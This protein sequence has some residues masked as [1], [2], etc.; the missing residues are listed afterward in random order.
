MEDN[1]IFKENRYK[2]NIYKC[3]NDNNIKLKGLLFLVNFQAERFDS[4]EQE[5]LLFFNSLFPVKR[6]W[7]NLIIIFTHVFDDPDGDDLEDMMN[8]RNNAT[9][10]IL[11]QLMEKVQNVS[12]KVDSNNLTFEYFN[13]FSPVKNERQKKRNLEVQKQLEVDLKK[14]IYKDPIY[15]D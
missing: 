12:Y 14:F 6:F 13:S 15:D 8:E 2:S 1:V 5:T 10:K 7:N 4:N 11:T 3:L 9:S